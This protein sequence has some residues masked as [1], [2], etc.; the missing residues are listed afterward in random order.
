MSIYWTGHITSMLGLGPGSKLWVGCLSGDGEDGSSE[1]SEHLLYWLCEASTSFA[2]Q[3]LPQ[4][5]LGPLAQRMK[6]VER[7]SGTSI[8]L[9]KLL[10]CKSI[11]P[12]T[13]RMRHVCGLRSA[14]TNIL[15]AYLLVGMC[16]SQTNR[17]TQKH[18]SLMQMQT[19]T[20]K[21]VAFHLFR[22][23]VLGVGGL[24][25]QMYMIRLSSWLVQK[26]HISLH[27]RSISD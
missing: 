27:P 6:A 15:N 8:P 16:Q 5:G 19:H 13:W 9:L 24:V 10:T 2:M 1:S 17:H 3:V 4:L 12:S 23:L 11:Y 25:T 22:C 26:M 18:R 7:V 21:W 14:S 20:E